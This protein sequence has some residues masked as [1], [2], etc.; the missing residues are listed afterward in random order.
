MSI[1]LNIVNVSVF[2][3]QGLKERVNFNLFC[4][5]LV[6]LLDAVSLTT[7]VQGFIAHHWNPEIMVE[8]YM[9]RHTKHIILGVVLVVIVNYV[10]IFPTFGLESSSYTENN[11]T[12]TVLL[13][14]K[15]CVDLQLYNDIAFGGVVAAACQMCIFIRRENLQRITPVS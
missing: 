6:N 10:P 14:S 5:S 1:V 4:L 12:L 7:V 9:A 2:V 8:C 11:S 15:L 13:Y 3:T